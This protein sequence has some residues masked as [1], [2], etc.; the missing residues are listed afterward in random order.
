MTT[1]HSDS[2]AQQ[3]GIPRFID[4]C[5]EDFGR[6]HYDGHGGVVLVLDKRSL[7]DMERAFGRQIVSQLSRWRRVYKVKRCSDGAT[8]TIGHRTKRLN[9]R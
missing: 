2:R 5:L 8:I 7:R 3:R 6:E 1:K 9:R 4:R